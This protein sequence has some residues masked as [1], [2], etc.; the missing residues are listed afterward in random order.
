M[1]QLKGMNSMNR[2]LKDISRRHPEMVGKAMY[3]EMQ[4]EMTE[5]KRR[6]PVETGVLR[7]SGTVSRPEI[8]SYDNINVMLSFGGAAQDYAIVQHERL[9]F[10]HKVGQAKFLESVLNES[11]SHMGT[12]IARRIHFNNT[13]V[14]QALGGPGTDSP[15]AD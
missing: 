9:D 2:K 11:Q 7:A 4:I 10:V 1:L 12:R 15:N 14:V 3:Q 8:D 6:C 13:E 5:A